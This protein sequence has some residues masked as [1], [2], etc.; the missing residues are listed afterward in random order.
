[1]FPPWQRVSAR[2]HCDNRNIRR[3][4]LGGTATPHLQSWHGAKRFS[5]VLSTKR[6]WEG[7]YL[8]PTRKFN[9]LCNDGWTCIRK[10]LLKMQEA[11]GA[12][13]TMYGGAGRICRKIGGTFWK[14]NNVISRKSGLYSNWYRTYL[15]YGAVILIVLRER[16]VRSQSNM[17]IAP[18][19]TRKCGSKKDISF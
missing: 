16:W 8:Q 7:K 4:A 18:S 15:L 17:I 10:L 6:P 5:P 1:M 14:K 19:Y 9:F 2:R 13:A 3:N 11:A 12:T